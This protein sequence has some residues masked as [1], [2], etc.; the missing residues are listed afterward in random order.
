MCNNISE[1]GSEP[2][3]SFACERGSLMNKKAITVLV[4]IIVAV[5]IFSGCT[6]R[7]HDEELG[8]S[9]KVPSGAV[10]DSSDSQGMVYIY[11]Q[12]EGIPYVMVIRYAVP[13]IDGFFESLNVL[14]K[15]HYADANLT[16]GERY[17]DTMGG[18]SVQCITYTYTVQANTVRDTRAVFLVNGWLY[19]FGSK[20]IP[21]Q[22]QDMS[23]LLAYT[24]EN[25][26]A[27]GDANS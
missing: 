15:T 22:G 14:M 5:S 26:E 23:E 10:V 21:A 8:I 7:W 12:G 20:D 19:M 24:I 2:V 27:V 17:E 6:N 16:V 3:I 13:E 4:F 11:P 9:I 1:T 18:R 25:F